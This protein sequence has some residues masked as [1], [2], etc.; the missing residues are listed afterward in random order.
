MVISV[1][2]N[3]G[4][5]SLPAFCPVMNPVLVIFCVSFVYLCSYMFVPC[6]NI[7]SFCDLN[8]LVLIVRCVLFEDISLS[9]L[10]LALAL[11]LLSP[12]LLTLLLSTLFLGLSPLKQTSRSRNSKVLF[13]SF[14]ALKR[15]DCSTFPYFKR[16]LL[17]IKSWF[18]TRRF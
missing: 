1:V 3:P 6:A 8:V 12:I 17:F 11:V 14:F 10:I 13:I 7:S 9:V 2:P 5:P 18:L 16:W 15:H 4:F